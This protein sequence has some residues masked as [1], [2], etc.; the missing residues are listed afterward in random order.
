MAA[1]P[2]FF[3]HVFTDERLRERQRQRFLADGSR[4]AENIGMGDALLRHR[5][6]EHIDL[7]G[8]SVNVCERHRE[9]KPP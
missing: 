8:M 5:F 3:I 6:P 1:A 7:L 2:G 9:T 4:S